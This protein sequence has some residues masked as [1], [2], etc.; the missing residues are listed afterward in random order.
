M[1][2]QRQLKILIFLALPISVLPA[3]AEPL[4]RD[5]QS[6]VDRREGCD[7]LR[8]GISDPAEMQHMNEMGREL[9]KL[10]GG[11]DKKLVELKRKYAN[12]S[13]ILQILNQFEVGIEAAEVVVRKSEMV[14]PLV[15][16]QTRQPQ[17]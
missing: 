10:C 12:N 4:P 9:R 1:G 15:S 14:S 5:V 8:R 2:T 7:R 6:F 16:Q 17:T 11:T 3:W 13:T